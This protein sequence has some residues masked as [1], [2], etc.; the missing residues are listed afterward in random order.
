MSDRPIY[1]ADGEEVVFE[2][3]RLVWTVAERELWFKLLREEPLELGGIPIIPSDPLLS[4]ELEPR[5]GKAVEESLPYDGELV[6]FVY[7]F[8]GGCSGLVSLKLIVDKLEL[9]SLTGDGERKRF[10]AFIQVKK[11]YKVSVIASNNDVRFS[12]RPAF[13]FFSRPEDSS[14]NFTISADSQ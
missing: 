14:F 8:P 6:F 10:M 1:N 5:T 12:H 11:G 4:V 7:S 9:A 2:M 3:D 13:R